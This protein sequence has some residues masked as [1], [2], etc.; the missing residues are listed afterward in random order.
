MQLL[1]SLHN[2]EFY[3]QLAHQKSACVKDVVTVVTVSFM[4]KT[5]SLPLCVYIG[6]I[7]VGGIYVVDNHHWTVVGFIFC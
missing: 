2:K 5:L 6:I 7:S 3:D 4:K 1:F